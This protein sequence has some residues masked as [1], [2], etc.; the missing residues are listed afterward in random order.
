M[1]WVVGECQS[2]VMM[3]GVMRGMEEGC[4]YVIRLNTWKVH[5]AGAWDL[6]GVDDQ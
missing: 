1:E 5:R 3:G 4:L 2:G 6:I